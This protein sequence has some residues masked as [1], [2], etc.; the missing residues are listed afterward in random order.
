MEWTAGLYKYQ[1]FIVFIQNI[2]EIYISEMLNR[3]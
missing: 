3:E 1:L 2:I